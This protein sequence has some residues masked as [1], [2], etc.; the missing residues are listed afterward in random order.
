MQKLLGYVR[1]I[2]ASD[3]SVIVD[4]HPSDMHPDYI[5]ARIAAGPDAPLF[6][7][8]LRVIARTAAALNELQSSRVALEIMNEPPMRAQVWRPMREAAYAEVRKAAPRLL[9]VLDGGE[10]GIS[11]G[12]SRSTVIAT[13]RRS[14]SLFTTTGRGSSPIRG[15]PERTRSI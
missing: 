11:R 7:E 13:I 12:P 10:E 5:G 4:F 3:L 2:L 8:Y 9:L 1:L 14:C 6:K 15:W